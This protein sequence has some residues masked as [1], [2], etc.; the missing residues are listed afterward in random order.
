VVADILEDAG[1]AVVEEFGSN[2]ALFV[3]L[4]VRDQDSWAAAVAAAVAT[5]GTLNVLINNAAAFDDPVAL[6]E[7]DVKHFRHVVEVN[8]TGVLLGMQAVYEPMARAGEGSIIN[9]SSI[10][11]VVGV[12][13]MAPY[14]ATKFAVRGLT[15]VAAAEWGAV[16][17]RVNAI[18]PGA[19]ATKASAERAARRS[20]RPAKRALGRPGTE[21]EIA[22]VACFLASNRSSYCTGADFLVDGGMLASTLA[23]DPD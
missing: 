23:K 18:L 3:P 12:P 22:E 11:G 1:R 17:I 6:A 19:I 2:D 20:G 8:Q 14:T 5:F 10:A 16:G 4:D 13:Q 7:L 15:R 9:I 21:A